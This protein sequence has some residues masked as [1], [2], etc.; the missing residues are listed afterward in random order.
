MTGQLFLCTDLDRTVVP[1]GTQPETPG[2]RERF[3]RLVNRPEVT[4]AYVTG[5]HRALVD[6]AIVE[7]RLPQPDFAITDVGTKIYAWDGNAWDVWPDWESEVEI[8]WAGHE[9]ATV[10]H[11]LDDLEILRLQEPSKQNTHKL[12]YY[13]PMRVDRPKLDAE[14]QRRL[15]ANRISASLVWS[16]DE[17]A[18]VGLLDVLPARATKLHAVDFLRE[19]LGFGLQQTLF[20]GDS[21]NDLEV[22]ESTVPSVLVANAEPAVREAALSRARAAGHEDTLYLAQ[23]GCMG[24]NGNYCAGILEGV[25]H[26]RPELTRWIEATDDRA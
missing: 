2:V 11:Y 20:A 6:Q 25:V 12:S 5:R 7:Y 8:D 26:F 13:L 23:G 19:H 16:V 18:G 10:S 3:A 1:N 14:I 21:G 4:L 17:P 15:R 9:Y 22:M 24:M